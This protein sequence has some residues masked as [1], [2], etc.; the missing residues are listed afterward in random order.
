VRRAIRCCS[1]SRA[2]RRGCPQSACAAACVVSSA[3]VPLVRHCRSPGGTP[4]RRAGGG[5]IEL[6]LVCVLTTLLEAGTLLLSTF[7]VQGVSCSGF[8]DSTKRALHAA[9]W[10]DDC[11]CAITVAGAAADTNLDTVIGTVIKLLHVHT[12]CICVRTVGTQRI[13]QQLDGRGM[14]MAQIL[15]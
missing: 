4:G 6:L 15:C 8:N 13:Q 14:E 5:C 2:D 12:Y 7:C 11:C 3:A 1:C 10:P 9:T